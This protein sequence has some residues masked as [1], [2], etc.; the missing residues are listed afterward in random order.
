MSPK[1]LDLHKKPVFSFQ[2]AQYRSPMVNY[3][4]QADLADFSKEEGSNKGFI[5]VCIDVYSRKVHGH[6]LKTKSEKEITDGFKKFFQ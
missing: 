6:V 3:N 4:W 1:K 5:L 2:R